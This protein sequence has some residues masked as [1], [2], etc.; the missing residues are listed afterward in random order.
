MP[1]SATTCSPAIKHPNLE[2][3]T[4]E[5][6]RPA[7]PLV[8]ARLGWARLGDR[9]AQPPAGAAAPTASPCRC[10]AQPVRSRRRCASQR[11]GVAAECAIKV[12]SARASAGHDALPLPTRMVGPAAGC[13]TCGR[14]ASEAR[15]S[16]DWMEG[17]R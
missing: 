8:L 13:W 6:G 4:V 11:A 1:R 15:C 17:A 7:H 16:S 14:M 9:P 10:E 3:V 5:S 12:K 2:C